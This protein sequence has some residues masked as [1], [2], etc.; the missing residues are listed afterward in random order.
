MQYR[1]E[2]VFVLVLFEGVA[3]GDEVCGGCRFITWNV[4]V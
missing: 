1:L 3:I 2:Y 4:F